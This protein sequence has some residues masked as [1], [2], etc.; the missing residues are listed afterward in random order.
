MRERERMRAREQEQE[1]KNKR[2]RERGRDREK[3]GE[4]E[5]GKEREIFS[6]RRKCSQQGVLVHSFKVVFSWVIYQNVLFHSLV[7]MHQH[8]F[9]KKKLKILNALLYK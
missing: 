8:F 4:T 1:S 6:N 5:K 3:Q 7:S 9:L 2:E